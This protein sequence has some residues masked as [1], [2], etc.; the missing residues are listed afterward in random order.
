MKTRYMYVLDYCC[1]SILE[2]ELSKEDC[3]LI[4]DINNDTTSVVSNIL[5]QHGISEKNCNYMLSDN[6]LELINIK[7]L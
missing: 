5:K 7:R 2:I 3:E 1:A 6:K 4:E